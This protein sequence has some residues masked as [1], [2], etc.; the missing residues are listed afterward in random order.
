MHELQTQPTHVYRL[1]AGVSSRTDR[2]NDALAYTVA[3][4]A[5]GYKVAGISSNSYGPS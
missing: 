4:E 5:K 3:V 2:R 1:T